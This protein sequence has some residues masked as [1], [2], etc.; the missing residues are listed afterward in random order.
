MIEIWERDNER[1]FFVNGNKYLDIV[2]NQWNSFKAHK[3]QEKQ[4]RVSKKIIR[5]VMGEMRV[6]Q[7]GVW[8]KSDSGGR[9]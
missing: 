2:N 4:D 9:G 1:R 3:E 8:M 7:P 5:K 6:K